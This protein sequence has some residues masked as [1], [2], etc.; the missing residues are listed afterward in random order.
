[1]S[2][3]RQQESNQYLQGYLARCSQQCRR[4]SPWYQ[5]DGDTPSTAYK[6]NV[7]VQFVLIVLAA[8]SS[9]ALLV[10]N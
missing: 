5:W 3:T 9:T 8:C 7:S 1:L 10:F 6:H 4:G 2:F